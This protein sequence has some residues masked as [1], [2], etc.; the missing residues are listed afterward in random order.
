VVGE[1]WLREA[2]PIVGSV[3]LCRS[4]FDLLHAT[5]EVWPSR[6][7]PDGLS[8]LSLAPICLPVSVWCC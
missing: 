2:E 6:V 8:Y 5:P 1:F 4:Q 7:R 3:N